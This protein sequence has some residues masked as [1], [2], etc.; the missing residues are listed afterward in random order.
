MVVMLGGLHLEM[1]AFKAL[2]YLLKDSRWTGALTETE[3]ATART[4]DSFISASHVK[5]TC[6]AHQ[7]TACT[8]FKL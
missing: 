3:I 1:G 5:K 8:L 4:A 7:V 6:L 2:F